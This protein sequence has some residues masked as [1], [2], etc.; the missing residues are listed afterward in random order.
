MTPTNLPSTLSSNEN[1]AAAAKKEDVLPVEDELSIEEEDDE[2]DDNDKDTANDDTANSKKSRKKTTNT[3]RSDPIR[4]YFDDIGKAA[5]LEV[6][7]EFWLSA[8]MLAIHRL[9]VIGR[10]HPIASQEEEP[11]RSIYRAI[12]TE[13]T[14]AWERVQDDIKRWGFKSPDLLSI[15]EEARQLRDSWDLG[16]PSYLRGYLNNSLWGKDSLWDTVAHNA[17]TVFISLYSLP[18]KTALWLHSY[19]EKRGTFSTKRTF[20]NYLPS[21]EEIDTNIQK[22]RDWSREAHNIIVRSNLRLVISIAKRYTGRG[23]SFLDLIQ[24]G[25]VG[26]LRAISKFDPARGYKFS[27]YATWWI[28][29][30][31]SRS[32]ADQGRTIRIPV[33]VHETIHRLSRAKREFTQQYNREPS[34]EE[35]TLK[36]GFL[37]PQDI[38]DIQHSKMK[39]TLMSPKLKRR[40]RRATRKVAHIMQASTTPLSLDSPV[41]N[42]DDNNKLADFIEDEEAP[43]PAEV[44]T[45]EMLREQVKNALTILSER[46]RQVLELRFGLLDG[47]EHTLEE[48]GKYFNVTRERIRQIEAKSLRKLRHP[49]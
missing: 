1:N 43:Q 36:S 15:L 25:N 18:E 17:F 22:L 5:L 39:N 32:I 14:T 12:F 31:V 46:E 21:D 10:Q 26:L 8:R 24:E 38:K 13:M 4:L 48:V 45:R 27:T 44:T 41:G 7:Q 28:R 42:N 20:C 19:I 49:T 2:D 30:S 23:N 3:S 6:D 40:L 37:K 34:I 29:Q 47:K 16:Q 35:L 11:A 9:D 33:H